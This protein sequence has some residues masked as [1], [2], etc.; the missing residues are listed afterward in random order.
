[1]E[2]WGYFIAV[3]AVLIDWEKAKNEKPSQLLRN[4]FASYL[5]EGLE[6]SGTVMLLVLMS[7]AAGVWIAD[8]FIPFVWLLSYL[9]ATLLKK[10]NFYFLLLF[11]FTV[12]AGIYEKNLTWTHGIARIFVSGI[13]WGAFRGLLAS[14]RMKTLFSPFPEASRGIPFLL[15]SSAVLSLC[16]C[17]VLRAFSSIF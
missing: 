15:F 5:R 16:L 12:Y 10:S 7:R 13:L 4:S 2:T 17:G 8:S 1:M 3:F 14:L 11:S 6:L 9:A